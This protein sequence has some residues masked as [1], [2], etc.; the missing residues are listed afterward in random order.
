MVHCKF[1]NCRQNRKGE[2][3]WSSISP[4]QIAISDSSHTPERFIPRFHTGTDRAGCHLVYVHYQSIYPYVL[5]FSQ[6]HRY[7]LMS[8]TCILPICK[9]K[10]QLSKYYYSQVKQITKNNLNCFIN[11]PVKTLW[12][13][14]RF[15]KKCENFVKCSIWRRTT[16]RCA[17][18]WRV[19]WVSATRRTLPPR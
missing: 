6:R 2:Q 13:C 7:M 3:G 9:K 15:I 5:Q 10:K 12:S 11:F 17:R 19:L 14:K 4:P 8:I 16:I 1:W 18:S